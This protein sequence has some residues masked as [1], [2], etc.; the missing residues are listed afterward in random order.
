MEN[1]LEKLVKAQDEYIKFLGKEIARTAIYLHIHRMSSSEK[2]I[3][4]GSK[5]RDKINK[6]RLKVKE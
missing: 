2:M 6:L 4:K 3:N 1:N 5:L